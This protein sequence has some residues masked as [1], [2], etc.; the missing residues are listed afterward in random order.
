MPR[1]GEH[2]SGDPD[3]R[4]HQVV[5]AS[6]PPSCSQSTRRTRLC[7]R[8]Q[9]IVHQAYCSAVGKSLTIL[10]FIIAPHAIITR[11]AVASWRHRPRAP[12]AS[13]RWETPAAGLPTWPG[14]RP[15]AFC[16]LGCSLRFGR[17]ISRVVA[18]L[19][20]RAILHPALR[21]CGASRTETVAQDAFDSHKSF[22]PSA[23]AAHR[24]RLPVVSRQRVCVQARARPESPSVAVFAAPLEP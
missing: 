11:R 7:K 24:V 18:F 21:P 10:C 4:L 20:A 15:R 23:R 8:Y 2:L 17:L 19:A 9:S 14:C 6:L 16:T 13:R 1:S 5:R 12:S 3:Q 22:G